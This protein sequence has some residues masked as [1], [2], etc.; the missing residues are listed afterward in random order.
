MKKTLGEKLRELREDVTQRQVAEQLGIKQQTYCG[1]EGDRRKPDVTEICDIC[2][3]YGVSADWLLGLTDERTPS[4][5]PAISI[6]DAPNS[7]ISAAGRDAGD[8]TRGDSD[9]RP[10]DR[11]LEIIENQ[12]RT[13]YELQRTIARLTATAPSR[14][15]AAESPTDYRPDREPTV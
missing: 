3:L 9:P 12:Q 5:R 13:I 8:V 2:A 10:S 7:M 4:A 14:R 11:L 6:S 1:W 15:D